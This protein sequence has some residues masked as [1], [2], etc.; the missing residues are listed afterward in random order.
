M[1]EIGRFGVRIVLGRTP[2]DDVIQDFVAEAREGI[3]ALDSK[4]VTFEQGPDDPALLGDIFRLIHT[5]KG[6]SGFLGLGRLQTVAHAAENVLGG[7]RDNTLP[8]TAQAVSAIL[9][10]VDAVRLVIDGIAVSGTEPQGDDRALIARLDAIF[11]GETAPLAATSTRPMLDRLGGE[12]TLDA[13]CETAIGALV[14]DPDIGPHFA[15]VDLDGL[16]ASLREGLVAQARGVSDDGFSTAVAS[17]F[18][19]LTQEQTGQVFDAVAT[20]LIALEADPDATAA[21]LTRTSDAAPEPSAPRPASEPDVAA[22]TIRVSVDVLE[23]LMTM[24]SELVLIRNQLI[25][26]LRGAPESPFAGPLHRLNQ[27]TSELQEGVMTTRMQPISG[28]WAK[29]PRLVRDLA[30]DLGKQIELVTSGQDT[31]LDRQILELI[32]D[33]LTHMIRNAADH[34]LET[35][36]ERLAAGKPATGRI[37]L[38]ARHEGGAIV[39][40]MADDGRGLSADRIR[41]KAVANGL[42]SSTQAQAMTDAEARQMIFLPG[43][44]TAQAVTAV[45]GRGVGMDVV[46]TNIE[47]I[48]GVIDLTSTEGHGTRFTI[49]IPLT[50]S[51]VSALIVESNGER[52]AMPQG[53]IVEL[54]SAN[55]S[56]G[57]RIEQINGASVLRLRDRLLPLVSLETMLGL[58]G[59]ET[60][61]SDACI[62]VARVGAFTFGVIVDRVFDTEEI[63]VKPVATIL[64]HLKIYSG[65]TILGDGSVIMILDFKGMSLEAGAPQIVGGDA[66]EPEA[67]TAVELTQPFLIFRAAT[68]ALKAAPLGQV[69]RIEELDASTIE[70]VEGRSVVQYRGA[71]MEIITADGGPAAFDGGAKRPLLVFTRDDR[72]LGLLVDEIVDIVEGPSRT[73][74]ASLVVAGRATELID[75]EIWWRKVGLAAPAEAVATPAAAATKRLLVVDQSPFT[76][77]LLGP[78]LAQA[79][80]AVEVAADPQRALA[81]H[82]DGAVYDLILADTSP[83]SPHARQMAQAFG[84]ASSWHATPLLGLGAHRLDSPTGLAD[85]AR[86]GEGEGLLAAVSETLEPMK[87][88][89]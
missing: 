68:E 7:F 63:V 38:S 32:K 49:R 44:S 65:A 79:G 14:A 82:D 71:L 25:Q 70:W 41:A 30:S 19:R 11:A 48:G 87:G 64:R 4:L 67:A 56:E 2:L 85:F 42:I 10:A 47:K 43:F 12:A 88:A 52:F 83:S 33:P 89:A 39:V 27:V 69:A 84:R 57:R 78:L 54:V 60:P 6:T 28:A 21:L 55:G 20:A 45:S 72:S 53:S 77:L 46:R 23:N 75:V 58:S 76:Q 81:L 50:L 9:D 74:G 3:E 86:S 17:A 34:G 80:Y 37:T 62:V 61:R 26:T 24:V 15:G 73:E 59:P 29:L 31:E 35:P 40:E 22:Q 13:A 36:A 18:P 16:Q 51:I 8:V 66:V 5:I 1:F